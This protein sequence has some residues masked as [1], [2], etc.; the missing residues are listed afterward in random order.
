MSSIFSTPG[1][2]RIL[3]FH[4]AVARA[5]GEY[6]KEADGRLAN[7]LMAELAQELDKLEAVRELI[8]VYEELCQNL[9][10]EMGNQN[11]VKHLERLIHVVKKEDA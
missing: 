11:L 4:N 3:A 1:G 5:H 7:K 8:P 9:E 6:G 10:S 2:V